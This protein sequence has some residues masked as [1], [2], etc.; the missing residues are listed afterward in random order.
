M[1][2]R[3]SG[4]LPSSAA[5]V[6]A[7]ARAPSLHPAAV[8]SPA[9]PSS[10]AAP[11]AVLL[12]APGL[13]AAT[14][15]SEGVLPMDWRRRSQGKQPLA[16]S[17]WLLAAWI[18]IL[19]L[20]L[21]TCHHGVSDSLLGAP[22]QA[23]G[24]SQRRQLAAGDSSDDELEE[25]PPSPQLLE[26]CSQLGSWS[27]SESPS[28]GLRF[29]PL[30]V[31]M[32]FESLQ[33]QQ[34]SALDE[35]KKEVPPSAALAAQLGVKRPAGEYDDEEDEEP[36]PSWKFQRT[37]GTMLPASSHPAGSPSASSPQGGSQGPSRGPPVSFP[38]PPPAGVGAAAGGGPSDGAAAAGPQHPPAGQ[39]GAP[40]LSQHPLLRMTPLQP[41]VR[42]RPFNPVVLDLPASDRFLVFSLL[43]VRRMMLKESLTQLNA[44]FM[45]ECGERMVGYAM[46]FFSR[47]LRK[48]RVDKLAVLLGRRL[49]VLHMLHMAGRVVQQD[50]HLQ[51]WWKRLANAIQ[52]SVPADMD[53][54]GLHIKGRR[55]LRIA[56]QLVPAIEVYKQGG[57]LPANQLADLLRKLFLPPDAVPPFTDPRQN[58]E[59][60]MRAGWAPSLPATGRQK[61]KRTRPVSLW[62][63]RAFFAN[64]R[65][66]QRETRLVLLLFLVCRLLKWAFKLTPRR[67]RR[68]PYCRASQHKAG[69]EPKLGGDFGAARN[70]ELRGHLSLWLG[71]AAFRGPP[72]SRPARGEKGD[73]A[74]LSRG[75]LLFLCK[76]PVSF[77]YEA[78]CGRGRPSLPV[79]RCDR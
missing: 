40:A 18:A 9:V 46:E 66:G 23:V 75:A 45:V 20:L 53:E 56:R 26:I 58:E 72:G 70:R 73:G 79:R 57:C 19:G 59:G 37:E 5:S 65:F 38:S 76:R 77:L 41:G 7:D 4:T 11:S 51:P 1:E 50:W 54:R 31:Q 14:E 10:S 3:V 69:G 61:C 27:P 71:E 17:K 64:A 62:T 42:A 60:R 25:G 6:Q 34:P 24:G 74:L 78:P 29:S 32:F 30:T 15:P 68:S 33:G 12:E 2:H 36:G 13:S 35:E 52:S 43:R 21:L 39:A 48:M 16:A 47:P 63:R 8:H 49:L 28:R 44:H 22:Q 55:L 67:S